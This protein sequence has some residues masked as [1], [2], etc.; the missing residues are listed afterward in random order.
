MHVFEVVYGLIFVILLIIK[1]FKGREADRQAV[2]YFIYGLWVL[3]GS[4]LLS[5]LVTLGSPT[6]GV[7]VGALGATGSGVLLVLGLQTELLPKS[8]AREPAAPRAPAR[9]PVPVP[10]RPAPP[11]RPPPKVEPGEDGEV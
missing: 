10:P 7:I 11:R 5:L 4:G 9:E 1:Y 8:A 3:I 2:T 6:G